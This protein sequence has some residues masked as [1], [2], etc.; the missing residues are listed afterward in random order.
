MQMGTL[1]ALKEHTDT[2]HQEKSQCPKAAGHRGKL[3]YYISQAFRVAKKERRCCCVGVCGY[4][5][6]AVSCAAESNSP[7]SSVPLRRHGRRVRAV[8]RR[9]R[10]HRRCQDRPRA[11][12]AS[13]TPPPAR[14]A[15]SLICFRRITK[16]YYDA[17][18]DLR[19]AQ[20]SPRCRCSPIPG[21]RLFFYLLC[22]IPISITQIHAHKNLNKA[23]RGTPGAQRG[24]E[25]HDGSTT[26]RQ[27]TANFRKANRKTRPSKLQPKPNALSQLD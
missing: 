14:P 19:S 2:T 1:S 13:L 21:C 27:L 6:R 16:I 15:L 26:R 9:R 23:T 24:L 8:G 11:S 12:C 20:P 7:T 3:T 25:C 18:F 4:I 17:D 10:P 5:P 22:P